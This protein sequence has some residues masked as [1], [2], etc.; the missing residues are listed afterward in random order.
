MLACSFFFLLGCAF[1][2]HLG[3][4]ND[5]ALFAS[6]LYD[7]LG[8]AYDRQ[9]FGYKIPVMVMTYLGALKAWIYAGIFR[10]WEPGAASV[11]T[12][13]LLAGALTVW[14]FF[15][16][17][18]RTASTRAALIGCFLL[19]ADTSFLLTAT[20][21]WGPVALQ[22]LLLVSAVL[23]LAVFASGRRWEALAGACF[24][25]GL[26][27]WDKALF[28]WLIAGLGAALAVVYPRDILR[29]FTP[30]RAAAA[31]LAFTLGALPL[32][33]YNLNPG[34]RMETFR[35]NATW[36][37]DDLPGKAR[38]LRSSLEGSALLG[39]LVAEDHEAPAPREAGSA[40]ERASAWLSA[41]AGKPRRNLFGY[42]FALSLGLA[43]W[44]WLSRRWK[45]E[46]RLVAAALVF[47]AA[48]WLQMALTR[49]AGGALHHTILLW[50]APHLVMAVALAAA[51]R[52]VRGGAA[53]AAALTAVLAAS[54]VLVTN[55]YFTQMIRNGGG[56]NWSEAVYPLASFVK[57]LPARQIYVTDWGMLDTLRLLGRG[58]L[59]LNVGSD[60]VSRPVLDEAGLRVVHSWV[61]DPANVFV[62]HTEGNEFFAGSRK[63]LLLA[64]EGFGLR[65]EMLRVVED[66][67]GRRIFE[68]FRFVR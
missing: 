34:H 35:S 43:L 40:L 31:V 56:L 55:Q 58:S 53:A 63:N 24:L 48:A 25:L 64:A 30:G 45:G 15:L 20:F 52:Q 60:P 28:V 4:Q 3:I 59:P 36:S 29:L 26:G 17:L 7:P 13:M 46:G 10:V 42:A 67:H 44:L 39:W 19:A 41:A 18:R 16:F 68:V 49:N 57:Q 22:H 23:L 2:P 32:L 61:S 6:G 54:G 66:R 47:L 27:A 14:L 51:S 65:M 38:L 8:L 21:D 1:I 62:G 5:E 50:P 11:R 37:A 33:L 12:P 9:V